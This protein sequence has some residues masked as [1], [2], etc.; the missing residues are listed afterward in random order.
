MQQRLSR[1][2]SNSGQR[3]W[4]QVA[5][6]KNKRHSLYP[7]KPPTRQP[8]QQL[9]RGCD[10]HIRAIKKHSRA[11]SGNAKRTVIQHA[12]VGLAIGKWKE[13]G[14]YDVH[15]S[16]AFAHDESPELR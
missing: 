1:A 3:L 4:P 6:F 14:P 16:K 13:P 12:L 9:W 5:Y 15:A 2:H 8:Y 11:R 10:K 7:R